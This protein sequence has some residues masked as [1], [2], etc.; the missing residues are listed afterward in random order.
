[1]DGGEEQGKYGEFPASYSLWP[2]KET[3]YRVGGVVWRNTSVNPRALCPA[4]AARRDIEMAAMRTISCFS[5]GDVMRLVA[6]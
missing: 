4:R 6:L 2:G 1:M 3:V 5:V